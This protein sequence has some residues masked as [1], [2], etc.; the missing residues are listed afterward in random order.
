MCIQWC[1]SL[2]IYYW[3]G[4]RTGIASTSIGLVFFISN[5]IVQMFWKTN[6]RKKISIER[7]L[8]WLEEC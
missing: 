6:G 4:T 2:L 5:E 3:I 1:F 7:L 8:Y